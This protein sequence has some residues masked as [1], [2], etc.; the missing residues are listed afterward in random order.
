MTTTHTPTFSNTLSYIGHD[1]L[2][3]R[4]ELTVLVFSVVLPIFFYLLF[5]AM[6]DYADEPV[7]GGNI[8]ALVMLGMAVYAG[9]T[10][11]VGAAGSTIT[12]AESGWSRQL[13]L[14]PLRPWQLT[15]SNMCNV[16]LR[17]I[18]PIASVFIV[19][20]LTR[21]EMQPHLW[22]LAFI[23]CVLVCIPFGFYGMACAMAVP[24]SNTVAIASTSIVLL[25]FAGNLFIPLKEPLLEIGRFTPMYGAASL[26][27]WPVSRGTQLLASGTTTDPMWWAWANIAVWTTVFVTAVLLLRRRDKNRK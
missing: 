5:G 15:L 13:A 10:G 20:A 14:T 1:L 23:T 3:L 6:D 11:A 24:G 4:R 26:A 21:A 22:L 16:A 7:N 18:L 8:S 27:R 19:G 9:V 12:E 2:R 25:S 17:A